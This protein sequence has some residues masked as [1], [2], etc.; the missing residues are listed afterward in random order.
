MAQNDKI[1]ATSRVG[2]AGDNLPKKELLPTIVLCVCLAAFFVKALTSLAWESATWD[3]TTYLGLG[4]Y[5][6]QYHRW[7]APGAILHPPL[8]Y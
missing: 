8:S 1:V 4:K 6:L 3:E 2:E 5:I 7:D